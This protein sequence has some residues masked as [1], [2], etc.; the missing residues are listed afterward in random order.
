MR[1][2]EASNKHQQQL[3]DQQ[4]VWNSFP[5]FLVF[6][7]SSRYREIRT[8]YFL[9]PCSKNYVFS[10]IL[11]ENLALFSHF[12]EQPLCWQEHCPIKAMTVDSQVKSI[13]LKIKYNGATRQAEW[14]TDAHSIADLGS[15]VKSLFGIKANAKL[16][17]AYLDINYEEIEMVFYF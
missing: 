7:K 9:V 3:S 17:F 16:S 14:K 5:R 2:Y 8:A 4:S 13:W 15:K 11:V 10:R 6:W 12:C 1:L